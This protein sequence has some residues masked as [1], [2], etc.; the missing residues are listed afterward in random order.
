[1]QKLTQLIQTSISGLNTP[2]R[3]D[4]LSFITGA[5]TVTGFA[6]FYLYPVPFLSIAILFLIWCTGNISPL[7]AAWRGYL[8]AMGMFGFGVSWVYVSI[9]NFG[10]MPAPM[11]ALAVLIFISILSAY[12]ATIGWLYAR[13]LRKEN[14][15][16][17]IVFCLPALWVLFE[18]VRSWLFT[19]FPWLNLGYSQVPSFMSGVAPVIGVY[20]ISFVVAVSAALLS[21]IWIQPDRKKSWIAALLVLWIV[22]GV[23][24]QFGWVSYSNGPVKV[25]MIQGNVPLA[26]KW[27]SENRKKIIA[28]YLRLSKEQGDADL[29]VWPEAAIPG[30]LHV[31]RNGFLQEVKAHATTSNT[32]YIIGVLEKIRDQGQGKL[33]NSAIAVN[34]NGDNEN[35]YR[36]QHL[37]PFGE[38]L[39]LKPLLGWLINFL[40]IPM[41]NL[42]H[43]TDTNNTLTV[44][45]QTVGVSICYEDAFGEE[46]IRALPAAGMLVNISEDAWF[47]DSFAPHQR[48]Q[49]AQMRAMEAGRPMIRA[50]NTGPSAAIDHTGRI[51]ARSGS[52]VQTVLRATIQP[53]Q[54]LTP[55][56]RFGNSP[57]IVLMVLVV[58]AGWLRARSR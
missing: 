34:A 57:V 11:A 35:V 4:I 49:I 33:F 47:G 31:V 58:I 14:R 16:Y 6:P 41:S 1:L 30:Y 40:H 2:V 29:I 27:A 24:G 22:I 53:M 21:M 25:A 12:V 13:F 39:P 10:N 19:G 42:S 48:L 5:L 44:A 7:R 36:K 52:F 45:G 43:S 56:A 15:W 28:D 38:Y 3:L 32:G 23:I 50:A 18:W 54:G 26:R 55:Y 9:H 51:T 8:F 20:G 37:V 17:L 46:V